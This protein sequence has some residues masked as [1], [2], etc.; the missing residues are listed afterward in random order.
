MRKRTVVYDKFAEE[1]KRQLRKAK[2][3]A[4][5]LQKQQLLEQAKKLDSEQGVVTDPALVEQLIGKL[6]SSESETE[7]EFGGF[8]AGEVEQAGE[9]LERTRVEVR[10]EKRLE[11][12]EEEEEVLDLRVF[13][14]ITNM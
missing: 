8:E 11:E 12:E 14:T 4:R 13:F 3:Q 9:L 6:S 7:S 10:G 5:E 1:K 2:R